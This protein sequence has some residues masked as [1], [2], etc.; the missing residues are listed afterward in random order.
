MSLCGRENHVRPVRKRP[1]HIG[2][3]KCR[4]PENH[5][6]GWR[7]HNNSGSQRRRVH[8]EDAGI[9]RASRCLGVDSSLVDRRCSRS[10][11]FSEAAFPPVTC[12]G[13]I[14]T[15]GAAEVNQ[16]TLRYPR[17]LARAGFAG[18]FRGS[19]SDHRMN[20]SVYF[21]SKNARREL[22]VRHEELCEPALRL[23]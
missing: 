8:R 22:Q 15:V 3:S 1:G 13:I 21:Q 23:F 6:S 9:S 2:K 12:F 11:I 19:P 18:K 10:D 17:K 16:R 4:D 5:Q 14:W 7:A 20:G